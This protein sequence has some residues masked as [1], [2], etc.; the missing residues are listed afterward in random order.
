MAQAFFILKHI[1]EIGNVV[2]F[3]T[4]LSYGRWLKIQH[5]HILKAIWEKVASSVCF[6]QFFIFFLFIFVICSYRS[7]VRCKWVFF[8]FFN[9]FFFFSVF[10]V[11]YRLPLA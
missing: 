4:Q 1:V 2:R 7:T 9:A 8:C 6:Y 5:Y 11:L 3:E 10:R